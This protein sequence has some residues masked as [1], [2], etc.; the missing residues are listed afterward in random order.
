MVVVA[1]VMVVAR[2][3]S[4]LFR[5]GDTVRTREYNNRDKT[6]IHDSSQ[7]LL[8]NAALYDD[9]HR[10]TRQL[11]SARRESAILQRIKPFIVSYYRCRCRA[12]T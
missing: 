10:A 9:S 11:V 6:V 5:Q 4:E 2:R 1:M 8:W 3:K 7:L 12:I